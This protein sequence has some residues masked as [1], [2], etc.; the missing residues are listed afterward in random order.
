M[1]LRITLSK[2]VRKGHLLPTSVCGLENKGRREGN[3]RKAVR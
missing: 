1:P 3:I 2:I